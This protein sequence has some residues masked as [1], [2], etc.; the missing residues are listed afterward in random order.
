MRKRG[1]DPMGRGR[2][3]ALAA[4]LSLVL[5][6][7]GCAT[8]DRG[9]LSVATTAVLQM[10]DLVVMGDAVEGRSCTRALE[11]R[12]RLA[13]EDA[14]ADAPGANAL[15]NASTTFERLCMVIR[16]TPVQIVR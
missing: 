1:S 7:L 3:A 6:A 5:F 15:A 11:N 2:R 9:T 10:P 4:A 14:L 16:G 12:M 8:Y 13:I